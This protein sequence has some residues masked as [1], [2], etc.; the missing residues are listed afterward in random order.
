MIEHPDLAPW[1][2]ERS[3]RKAMQ[4]L[5]FTCEDTSGGH[6]AWVREDSTRTLVVTD[7]TAGAALD[8]GDVTVAYY[9]AAD[10]DP[11]EGWTC[12]EPDDWHTFDDAEEAIRFLVREHP[13]R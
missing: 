5:G 8:C 6:Y 9:L 12:A 7:D 3:A 1:M 11:E 2:A 4:A 13:P 10:I